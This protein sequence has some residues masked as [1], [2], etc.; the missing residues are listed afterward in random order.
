MDMCGQHSASFTWAA[1]PDVGGQQ[2][3]HHNG[4]A[5]GPTSKP[6]VGGEGGRRGNQAAKG[7]SKRRRHSVASPCC[8]HADIRRRMDFC[9]MI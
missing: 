3:A 8:H 4:R 2:H 9:D 6:R 1:M 5:S 7:R